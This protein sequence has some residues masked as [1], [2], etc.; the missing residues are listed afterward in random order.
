M[1][2]N[3][4]FLLNLEDNMYL[5]I[6]VIASVVVLIIGLL[7]FIFMKKKNKKK[8]E[9]E[10]QDGQIQI[11]VALGGNENIVSLE[12]KGSRLVAVLNNMSIINEEQ[13][14]NLGV[15]SI[16]KMTSKITLVIGNSS[17]EIARLFNLQNSKKDS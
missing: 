15:S 13:L 1:T 16:I 17:S 12:A 6:A 9:K 4:K 11:I 7:I 2:Q 3:I 10:K 8:N 14:K 5:L